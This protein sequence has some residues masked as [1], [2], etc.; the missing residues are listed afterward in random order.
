MTEDKYGDESE[1][2]NR[3]GKK[4]ET[5]RKHTRKGDREE[6]VNK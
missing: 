3:R 1:R 2:E 6:R 4:G 5:V